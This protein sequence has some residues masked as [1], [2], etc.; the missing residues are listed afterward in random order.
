MDGR[1]GPFLRFRTGI[2]RQS[3]RV[4]WKRWKTCSGLQYT[5][6]YICIAKLTEW[7]LMAVSDAWH[8]S[9]KSRY[10]SGWIVV[11]ETLKL[12]FSVFSAEQSL[13]IRTTWAVYGIMIQQFP[14]D[15]Y[16]IVVSYEFQTL[17]YK[18]IRR[19]YWIVPGWRS[20]Y[21]DWLRAGRT[22]ARS[23]RP[24]GDKNFHP[25]C[26][27]DRL[28]GPP[29]LLSNGYRGILPQGESRRDVK[30]TTH[31]QLVLRLKKH[32]PIHSPV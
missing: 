2:H 23:S 15:T 27:P 25:P 1:R 21:S 8:D 12:T 14:S 11:S 10:P 22:R 24:G 13:G 6:V 4:N 19:K 16:K 28:W 30:L 26:R 18:Y 31:L 9:R 20:W 7:G 5:H 17:S 29:S 32:G 3:A